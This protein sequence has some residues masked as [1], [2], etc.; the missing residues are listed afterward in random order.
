M[1][2]LGGLVRIRTGS[3]DANAAVSDGKYPFFTCAALPLRIDRF[4]FD[5]ECAV[6]SG[7]GGVNV[8]YYNGKFDAYQRTYVI[9]SLDKQRLSVPYLWCFLDWYAPALRQKAKGGV[10]RYLRLADLTDAEIPLPDTAAQNRIAEKFLALKNAMEC[11]REQLELIPALRNARYREL[12]GG[13]RAE[14][15]L[16]NLCRIVRGSS[17]RP[18][19]K[20]LGGNVPWIRIG[21]AD[22]GSIYLSRTAECITQEGAAHSHRVPEGTVIFA[23]CGVS[24]GFAKITAAEGCIH[25]GWLALEDIAPELDKLFLVQSLSARQEYF[26]RIAPAGTQP[27]LNTRIMSIQPQIV[28]PMDMQKKFAEFI[29]ETEDL[30]EYARHS[31]AELSAMKTAMQGQVFR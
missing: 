17:P 16:G 6:L 11:R 30:S 9:E 15:T 13:M 24:L 12:F 20:Y 1:A 21:D 25:D 14:T 2:K 29:L 3:L 4:S 19:G 10:I 26:R 28:P 27:N 5:C 8:S 23:A 22:S 31:L 18:I 7:N